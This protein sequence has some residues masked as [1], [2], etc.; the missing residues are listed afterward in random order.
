[1]ATTH[2]QRNTLIIQVSVLVVICVGIAVLAYVFG[3]FSPPKDYRNINV[4]VDSNSGTIM[5]VYSIPGD[6]GSTENR[7]ST[8]WE[9][10]LY[11]KRGSEVYVTAATA[12]TT[13]GL[14]CTIL[15]DGK[16]WKTDKTSDP[17]GKVFCAGIIP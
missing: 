10:S 12:G 15:L 8:P 7:A 11:V 6:P 5:L 17:N 16:V 4:R 2:N 13:G 3:V 14:S 1:M 9:K